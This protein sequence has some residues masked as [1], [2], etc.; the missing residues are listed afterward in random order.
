MQVSAYLKKKKQQMLKLKIIFQIFK[1]YDVADFPTFW[2][3]KHNKKVCEKFKTLPVCR[4]CN[5]QSLPTKPQSQQ[6]LKFRKKTFYPT[7]TTDKQRAPSTNCH[8]HWFF[9]RGKN[10][11]FKSKSTET[12]ATFFLRQI[13]PPRMFRST[14]EITLAKERQ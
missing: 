3:G 2:W 12:L 5:A 8:F 6:D 1:F 10:H 9:W 4:K 7:E 11:Q 13:L 14:S